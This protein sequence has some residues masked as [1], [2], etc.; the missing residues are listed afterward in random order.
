MLGSLPNRLDEAFSITG[1][2]RLS[3]AAD[4]RK[5]MKRRGAL[6]GHLAQSCI[7]EDH[8]RGKPVLVG[9]LFAQRTQH[10]K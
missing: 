6:L 7:V 10:F 5:L 4:A 2:L 8:V 1:K 9:Q 3:D